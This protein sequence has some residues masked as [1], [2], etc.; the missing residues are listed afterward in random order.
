L[1]HLDD[2]S[3]R[4]PLTH[5]DFWRHAGGSQRFTEPPNVF[6]DLFRLNWRE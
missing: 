4:R 5:D 3:C 2:L 1:S 6:D